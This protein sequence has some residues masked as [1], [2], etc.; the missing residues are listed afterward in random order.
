MSANLT[1]FEILAPDAI[2][3]RVFEQLRRIGIKR[4]SVVRASRA[5][6]GHQAPGW[7]TMAPDCSLIVAYG[8]VDLAG[9]LAGD[10]LPLLHPYGGSIF[11]CEARE[12]SPAEPAT[13]VHDKG[14]SK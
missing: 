12:L 6:S 13:T 4:F 5:A 1:R 2:A 3:D 7:Q 14:D 11:A 9:R 10:L 8:S